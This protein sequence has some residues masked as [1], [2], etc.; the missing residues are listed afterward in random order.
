M[1]ALK[2]ILEEQEELAGIH[3]EDTA[4]WH[5]THIKWLNLQRKVLAIKRG[6]RCEE[7]A[8]KE[9]AIC[10]PAGPLREDVGS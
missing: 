6:E 8:F 1:T 9:C 7:H 10:R 3:G 2:R 5:V 4:A